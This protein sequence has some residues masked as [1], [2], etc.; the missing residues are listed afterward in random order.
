MINFGLFLS[1]AYL[2]SNKENVQDAFIR[3]HYKYDRSVYWRVIEKL[4][5]QS[6]VETFD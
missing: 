4:K 2:P 3:L 6:V 5:I 1:K